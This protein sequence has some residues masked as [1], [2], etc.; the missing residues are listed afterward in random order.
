MVYRS[1]FLFNNNSR[2]GWL[3][4]ALS[5]TSW[6]EWLGWSTKLVLLTVWQCAACNVFIFCIWKSNF[7]D[8]LKKLLFPVLVVMHNFLSWV[9]KVIWYGRKFQIAFDTREKVIFEILLHSFAGFLSK[10]LLRTIG[11]QL[12]KCKNLPV[13]PENSEIVSQL[14]CHLVHNCYLL[15]QIAKFRVI[16]SQLCTKWH[17]SWLKNI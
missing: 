16:K 12:L 7:L 10:L 15:Y 11:R 8:H 2:L 13:M 6:I 9:F 3:Y 5:K 17:K 14:L 4:G 1:A